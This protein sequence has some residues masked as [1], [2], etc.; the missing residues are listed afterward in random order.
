MELKKTTCPFCLNG[1]TSAVVFDGYQYRMEYVAEAEVN[2]GRLC[3]RGNSASIVIDHP[4]RLAY[5]LLDGRPITW[6]EAAKLVRGWR[7]EVKP[8]QIALVYSRG[9]GADEVGRMFGLARE[10]G[11]RHVACGHIEPENAFS[12]RLEGTKDATLADLEGARAMLLVGDVFSTSPVAVGRM[13]DA[14][15]ADRKNRLVV[16]DSVR[17]PQSGFAH[18]F[19]QVRPGTE[20][21]ALVAIAALL[22]KSLK[23]DVDRLAAAAGVERGPLEQAAKAIAP[24]APGFVGAAAHFGRV[25][26]PAL[27]SLACQLVARAAR[28][29]FVGFRESA[30]PLGGEDFASLRKTLAA[31]DIR[32]LFWTGGMYPY[33]YAEVLPEAASAE[34]RVATS[35]FVPDPPVPGLVLPVTAELEKAAPAPTYWGPATRD[36]LAAPLSGSRDFGRVLELFGDAAEA[37]PPAVAATKPEAVLA[38]ADKAVGMARG[39]DGLLMLGEKKAIGL[40]GFHDPEDRLALGFAEAAALELDCDSFVRVTSPVGSRD[41]GVTVTDQVPEGA[42]LVGTN[43]H[44][45]RALFPLAVDEVSGMTTVVPVNV[46]VEKLAPRV[47]SPAEHAPDRRGGRFMVH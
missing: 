30:L 18:L 45:N 44:E 22:D 15:Y 3:P 40:R 37:E 23:A 12:V 9:R 26:H 4:Q 1:C 29:P 8:E 36:P 47:Q 31:G 39:G 6:D 34:Y 2:K 27:H 11:T 19:I 25:F 16:I 17:T 10:I 14:R 43:V 24:D 13:L 5:P 42:I 28:K 7:A 35:I 46:K 38:M 33:S 41:L 20:P 32:L 21:F